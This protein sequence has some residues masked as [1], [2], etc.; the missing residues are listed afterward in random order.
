M[1]KICIFGA[2]AVGG[3]MAAW[4]ARAGLDVSVVARGPHLAAMRSRGLRFVSDT[5]DF[6]VHVR[7][8]DDARELGPQDLVISAV[9]AHALPGVVD[10]MAP[11]LGPDTPVVFA[12][13]GVPWWYFHG[14]PEQPGQ[15]PA[16]QRLARLDPG[17]RLWNQLGVQR[18]I[19]CVV[20]SPNEVPNPGTV[21]NNA[22]VNTFVFGEPDNTLSPRL[23]AILATLQ[24]GLPGAS[25]TSAI[26]DVV[27][28]KILLNLTSSTLAALTMRPP[29][30]M[31]HDEPVLAVYRQ[32]LDE[33]VAVAAGCGITVAADADARIARMRTVRHPPSMLQDLLAGRP[34]E[35]DA[36]L[37]AVQDLARQGNVPTPVLDILLALL[38]QRVQAAA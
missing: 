16:S 1:N 18:A 14:L 35:I 21:R 30:E 4:L 36:L 29:I 13:N 8:S 28:S 12:I 38:R 27:W 25:A 32:L 3:H 22:T 23:Q 7:A 20:T 5:E 33:G 2:G 24:R 37:L 11:L 34:L 10:A 6:T 17:G 15:P 31:S 26:R 19:G 9:K